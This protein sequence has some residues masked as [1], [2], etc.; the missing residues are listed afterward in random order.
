MPNNSTLYVAISSNELAMTIGIEA[1]ILTLGG[2][3]GSVIAAWAL[4]KAL[5]KKKGEAA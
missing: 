1:I 2:T 5:Y 3:L 4:W